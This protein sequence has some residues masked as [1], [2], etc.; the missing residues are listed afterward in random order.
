M[1]KGEISWRAV[2]FESVALLV[3]IIGL[4]AQRDASASWLLF[5]ALFLAPDISALGYLVSPRIGA[6]GYN[7][8]HS[9]VGPIALALIWAAH[10]AFDRAIGYGFKNAGASRPGRPISASSPRHDLT[11]SQVAGN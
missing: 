4:Y 6:I 2:R 7:L 3:L 11:A 1:G 9:L 5:T 10:I 8:G